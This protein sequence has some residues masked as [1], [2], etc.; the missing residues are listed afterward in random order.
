LQLRDKTGFR[1]SLPQAIDELIAAGL[2][3]SG[4]ASH[5][6]LLGRLLVAARLLAPDLADPPEPARTPPVRPSGPRDYPSRARALTEARHG[7][8]ATWAELFGER[9][10]IA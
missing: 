8:A 2:V 7:I 3:P 1:P 10:E 4:F 5:Q 9:L 6:A